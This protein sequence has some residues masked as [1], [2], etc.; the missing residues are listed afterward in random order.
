MDKKE[1]L[2]LRIAAQKLRPTLHVGKD[3]LSDRVTQ[4]IALQLKSAKLVKIRIL[5][6]VE[7]DRKDIAAEMAR[8][9]SSELVDVRGSTVVLAR[10]DQSQI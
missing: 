3:G 2:R 1:K 4:E 6:S 7:G 5:S 8:R 9:T 10:S